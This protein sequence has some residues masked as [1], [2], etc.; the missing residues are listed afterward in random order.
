[1]LL[2]NDTG[3]ALR[4]GVGTFAGSDG[5]IGF[6]LMN[7][8][9]T[10]TFALNSSALS[11][12]WQDTTIRYYMGPFYVGALFTRAEIKA[13]NQGVDTIDAAGSGMGGGVGLLWPVGRGGS[14]S[15]DIATAS[16]PKMKNSLPQEIAIGQRLDLDLGASVDI[17]SRLLDFT[18]GYRTRTLGI[19]A[20]A[21]YTENFYQTYVG[22]RMSFF[23]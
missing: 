10:T 23:F 11:N 22:L 15:L 4:Y 8:S 9:D 5:Q 7:D 13:K 3:T 12:I 6:Q 14:I 20:D 19:K 21:N 2:S 16:I 17:T 1:M 18:F